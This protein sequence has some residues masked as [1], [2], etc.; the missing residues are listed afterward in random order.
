MTNRFTLQGCARLGSIEVK[1]APSLVRTSLG[2]S[3]QAGSGVKFGNPK[4]GSVSTIVNHYKG[5]VTRW[6]RKEGS[7]DFAW[8]SRFH[9]H[10]VRN[11]RAFNKIRNY[12][13][14]NPLK[15]DEDKFY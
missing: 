3:P 7:Y 5:S 4:S 10:I 1:L 13:I 6:A 9:D 8:Q 11:D 2:M 12:I 15:W 14:N